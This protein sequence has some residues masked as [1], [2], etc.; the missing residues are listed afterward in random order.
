MLTETFEGWG[1]IP[2][3]NFEE[4]KK[5]NYHIKKIEEEKLT[6]PILE[7]DD[8]SA[9]E[10]IYTKIIVEYETTGADW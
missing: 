3:L 5:K 6:I 10:S 1:K 8:K 4:F 7:K 9:E 2:Y